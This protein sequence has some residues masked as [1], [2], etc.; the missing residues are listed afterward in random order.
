M[1]RA[2]PQLRTANLVDLAVAR[3]FGMG[4]D[5][6][7]IN[8]MPCCNRRSLMPATPLWKRGHIYF[9]GC[10][11]FIKIGFALSVAQ[12]I[13]LLDAFRDLHHRGEWVLDHPDLRTFIARVRKRGDRVGE[14]IRQVA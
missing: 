3:E 9:A 6:L 7:L 1:K 14:Y 13:K 10:A 8:G 5:R 4:L 11:D 2:C 12:R